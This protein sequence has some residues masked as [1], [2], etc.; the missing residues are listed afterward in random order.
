MREEYPF[1]MEPDELEARLGEPNLRVVDLCR[2]EVH[3]QYHIPGAVHLDYSQI[4]SA[5]P[6]TGGLLPEATL[7]EALMQSIGI[8]RDT[9]IVAYDDEG[10]G[11]AGRLIWTLNA[12]GHHAS[13]LLNGGLHAWANEKHPLTSEPS[14]V[15][16]GDLTLDTTPDPAVV[17]RTEDILAHLKEPD[18]ALL[19]CRTPDEYRGRM[20]YAAQ[21][22]HI[23]GAVNMEWTEAMDPDRNLRLRPA[24]EL[25]ER[26]EGMGITPDKNV[27]VYCQ[28]HH[29]SAHTYCV[30]K[31][32]GYPR[33]QG[34]PGSWSEWGNRQ[35]LPVE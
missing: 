16:R 7:F 30:L 11:K 23:P 31:A 1:L 32:L 3:A 25:R 35:D 27:V 24:P 29:R 4:V 8:N 5:Q 9:H 19:D 14:A 12:Y 28:T 13:S 10:G 21:G 15:T 26:L 6:P 18:H 33:V 20:R 34:Y 2:G 17:A 22:G